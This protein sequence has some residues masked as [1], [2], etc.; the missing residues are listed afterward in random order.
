MKTTRLDERWCVEYDTADRDEDGELLNS[1]TT[2]VDTFPNVVAARRRA[3]A[4]RTLSD[5]GY[6][7]IRHERFAADPDLPHL[8]TWQE[9]EDD[10]EI[11]D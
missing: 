4:C 5:F 6:A 2:T 1:R 7:R 9:L 3:R 10:A 8:M 11:V